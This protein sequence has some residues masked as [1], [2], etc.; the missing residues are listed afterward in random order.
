MN[1]TASQKYRAQG[2]SNVSFKTCSAMDADI[3][4]DSLDLI[5]CVN[6][7]YSFPDA[8]RA[9]S[10]FQRWLKP[11]G[12]LFLIDLGRK[13]DVGDWARYIVESSLK[14]VGFKRTVKAFAKGRKAIGQNRRIRSE[15]DRG[16][17]WLHSSTQLRSALVEVGFSIDSLGTCYRDVCD[18][19]ICRK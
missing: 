14:R 10:V 9:I 4:A 1:R 6:A 12:L 11:G 17:Y 8:K 16:A 5:V 13:M 15:Q 18:I 2:L 7:L 3:A 19:A